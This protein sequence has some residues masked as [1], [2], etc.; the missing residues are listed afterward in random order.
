MA[1]DMKPQKVKVLVVDDT[2]ELLH[3]YVRQLKLLGYDPIGAGSANEALALLT[4]DFGVVMTDYDMPG[5]KG[6]ELCQEVKKKYADPRRTQ[7]VEQE[8][9]EFSEED[10]IR[11]MTEPKNALTKQYQKFF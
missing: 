3:A 11:I 4:P 1:T 10:L 6:D 2:P 8:V 7:V 5:M 9:E